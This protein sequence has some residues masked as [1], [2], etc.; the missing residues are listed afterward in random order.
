MNTYKDRIKNAGLRLTRQRLALGKMLFEEG[1]RHITAETFY[2]EARTN[3]IEVSLATIYNT[4][5]QF[6][7][8]GLLRQVHVDNSRSYFDTN[9]SDHHHFFLEDEGKLVDIP[10]EGIRVEGL[11]T[12]PDGRHIN[13]VD[14]IVRLK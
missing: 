4:L 6:R 12:A 5:H 11:P 14:V 13:S 8:A 7:D 2:D 1:N 10:S 9:V 3:G